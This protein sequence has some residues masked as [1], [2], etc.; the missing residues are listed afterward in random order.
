MAQCVYCHSET[1]L[2]FG[3]VPICVN[4]SKAQETKGKPKATEQ[5]IRTTLLEDSIAK[6]ARR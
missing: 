4:C 5:A 6:T 2:Y 1:E 3:D